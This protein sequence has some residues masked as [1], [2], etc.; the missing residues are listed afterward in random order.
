MT[1]VFVEFRVRDFKP[2]I[3]YGVTVVVLVFR[4]CCVLSKVV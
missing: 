4:V 3:V 1:V 2:K